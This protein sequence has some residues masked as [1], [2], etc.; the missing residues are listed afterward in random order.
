MNIRHGPDQPDGPPPC[1]DHQLPVG[2]GAAALLRQIADLTD[3]FEDVLDALERVSPPLA[4]KTR[5][6]VERAR[7]TLATYRDPAP[8]TGRHAGGQPSHPSA[9]W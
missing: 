8:P 3:D 2:K 1:G 6:S 7:L 5:A 9:P 4:A